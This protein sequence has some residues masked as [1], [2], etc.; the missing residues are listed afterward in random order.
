MNVKNPHDKFFQESFQH[1]SVAIAY[2]KN[3]MPKTIHTQ[4]DYESFTLDNQSYINEA[5]EET[6]SDI[7]YE[8]FTIASEN[9]SS[10]KLKI[11]LLFEHKSYVPQYPL[12]QVLEYM[13]SIWQVNQKQQQPLTFVIPIVIYHGEQDWKHRQLSEM[14]ETIPDFLTPYFP[15]FQIHL[16][17]ISQTDDETIK[18]VG[19][20]FLTNT[21]L[22]LKYGRQLNYVLNNFKNLFIFREQFFK[23]TIGNNHFT[24]LFLYIAVVTKIK[25]MK[26]LIVELPSDLQEKGL[27]AYEKAVR[28]GEERANRRHERLMKQLKAEWKEKLEKTR[29]EADKKAKEAEKAQIEANKK[30]KKAQVEADKK[31]KQAQIEADKKAKKAQM[32]ANKKAKQAQLEADKKAK[33]ETQRKL[34]EKTRLTIVRLLSLN[35]L[36][37]EAIAATLDVSVEYVQQIK[38]TLDN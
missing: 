31:A 6:F 19:A 7:V 11:A 38:K 3:F 12:L 37:I 30:A 35:A 26:D 5:L 33:L 15:N 4:L 10:T 14:F 23:G 36:S 1:R 20:N 34:E 9:T 8:C 17:N 22:A 29:L 21:F 25:D 24:A 32:E 18:S 16:T 27:S 13:L 28:E 2:V